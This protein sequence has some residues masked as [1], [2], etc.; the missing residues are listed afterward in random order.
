MRQKIVAVLGLVIAVVVGLRWHYPWQPA[1]EGSAPPFVFG[2]DSYVVT[3]LEADTVRTVF[4]TGELRFAADSLQT[5]VRGQLVE[6]RGWERSIW[7]FNADPT[8]KAELRGRLREAELASGDGQE[9]GLLLDAA[10]P[11]FGWRV[12]VPIAAGL[13]GLALLVSKRKGEGGTAKDSKA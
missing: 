9:T 6:Y 10:S 5:G 11:Q 2:P 1:A 7:R 8:G 13:W 3:E 12:L 4:R